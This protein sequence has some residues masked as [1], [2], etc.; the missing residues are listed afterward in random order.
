MFPNYKWKEQCITWVTSII[1]GMK[2]WYSFC[3]D[4][5]EVAS[6]LRQDLRIPNFSVLSWAPGQITLLHFLPIPLPSLWRKRWRPSYWKMR[7]LILGPKYFQT[8]CRTKLNTLD[9]PKKHLIKEMP[10]QN[11]LSLVTHHCAAWNEFNLHIRWQFKHVFLSCPQKQ[12]IKQSNSA[13]LS[14]SAEERECIHRRAVKLVKALEH[15]SS[16]ECLMELGF[17][18]LEKRR[19]FLQIVAKP[20]NKLSREAVE[21]QALKG[22]KICVMWCWGR[23]FS[24]DLTVLS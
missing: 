24:S 8:S 13:F 5:R 21:P 17:F 2:H 12:Q 22:F 23:W 20:C 16:E 7:R 4:M 19:R 6:G 9:L 3:P 11:S 10:I 14:A 1:I 18:G 15:K